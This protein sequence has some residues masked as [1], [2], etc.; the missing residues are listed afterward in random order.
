MRE[1]TEKSS[2]TKWFIEKKLTGTMFCGEEHI[3]LKF[4]LFKNAVGVLKSIII[5]KLKVSV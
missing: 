5:I 1:T 4:H 2:S 3:Y